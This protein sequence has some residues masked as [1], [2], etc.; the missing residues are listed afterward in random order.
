VRLEAGTIRAMPLSRPEIDEILDSLDAEIASAPEGEE[1]SVYS[2]GSQIFWDLQLAPADVEHVSR[3]LGELI[4]KY[5]LPG[6]AT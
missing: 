6:D 5:E 2:L 3:R 1:F 4:A